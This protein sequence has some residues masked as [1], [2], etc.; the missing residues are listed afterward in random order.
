MAST[1]TYSWSR[2]NFRV[3]GRMDEP[4][5]TRSPNVSEVRGA[6]VHRVLP[7]RGASCCSTERVVGWGLEAAPERLRQA[8][9]GLRAGGL[10]G[11][12]KDGRLSR[13]GASGR[14]KMYGIVAAH[15]IAT[16]H[17]TAAAHGITAARRNTGFALRSVW[18][19]NLGPV[20]V[21]PIL[22]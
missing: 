4:I 18:H 8:E 7:K 1:N 6:R 5:V 21:G 20:R 11:A 15:A 14:L 9:I 2:L 3:F 17:G 12:T 10:L 22:G 19:I 16:Y 13:C